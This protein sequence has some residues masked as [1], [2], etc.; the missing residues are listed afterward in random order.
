MDSD[1]FLDRIPSPS[2][3]SQHHIYSLPRQPVEGAIDTN[4]MEKIGRAEKV[5][6]GRLIGVFLQVH[7]RVGL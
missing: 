4:V 5:Q 1:L 3:H 6:R 2:S 7:P